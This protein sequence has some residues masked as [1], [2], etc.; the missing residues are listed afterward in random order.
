VAE[1]DRAA[2]LISSRWEVGVPI[3]EAN[4]IDLNG[5]RAISLD[6]KMYHQDPRPKRVL[7]V[8]D[9]PLTGFDRPAFSYE[10]IE[11]TLAYPN[12]SLNIV[13]G[14]GVSVVVENYPDALPAPPSNPAPFLRVHRVQ[15][16]GLIPPI[17]SDIRSTNLIHSYEVG[18]QSW[19]SYPVRLGAYAPNYLTVETG[20]STVRIRHPH[21]NTALTINVP[22]YTRNRNSRSDSA[23]RFAYEIDDV[24]GVYGTADRPLVKIVKTPGVSVT[25]EMQVFPDITA[26]LQ[27]RASPPPPVLVY[28]DI[29]EVSG[30]NR[31]PV[32]GSPITPRSGW[33]SVTSVKWT[34]SPSVTVAQAAFDTAI[35]FVP[36]VG[37][38]V[39]LAEFIYALGSGVD[40]W[41]RRQ[42]TGDLVLLGICALLPLAGV[43]L[44]RAG[45]RLLR[46]FGSRSE[47][48]L[49]TITDLQRARLSQEELADLRQAETLI[50]RGQRLP[51]ALLT[52]YRNVLD[53]MRRDFPLAQDFLNP[54]RN[55]FIN[56][57]LQRFYQAHRTRI[58]AQ[59]GTPQEPLAWVRAT[60]GRSR[61]LL[62]QLLGPDFVARLN[63]P[64]SGRMINLGDVPRPRGYSEQ[65][66]LSHINQ[67]NRD[68]ARITDRLTDFLAR[69]RTGGVIASFMAA[70]R[71]NVGYLWILKGNIAESFSMS[72]Q[73]QILAALNATNPR[74][75][76][77]QGVRIQLM[78]GNRLSRELLFSD[79]IMASIIDGNLVLRG[80]VEVKSGFR[81]GEQAAEQIFRWIE[82][83]ITDGSRVVIP[84]GARILD[85]AGQ[86]RTVTQ[87]MSF[88]YDPSSSARG[89]VVNLMRTDRHVIIPRDSG[90]IGIESGM[91]VAAG[92]QLHRLP[93]SSAELDYLA[94]RMMQSL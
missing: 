49:Q 64:G 66:L 57:E 22:E 11:G 61:A 47:S 51:D 91:H 34:P 59:G 40:R 35:G 68:S 8:E 89:R 54:E 60:R 6:Y 5:R 25:L 45:P 58:L 77:F 80:I 79:N 62:E 67:L 21:T 72:L 74:T 28:W 12:D 31:V 92:V 7:L 30:V 19:V 86:E 48:A 24:N 43:G 9:T 70:R 2:V 13:A 10:Y 53:R 33:R 38:L 81:G 23:V 3:F 14:P 41:G 15:D 78:S 46:Q 56:A 4:I 88:V 84:Q 85:A 20:T 42:S 52:S 32:Q 39:D 55:G 82:R 26:L 27:G 94:A 90:Y 73:R 18:P 29:Y 71:V 65:D 63:L 1:P 87:A 44:M 36:V 50:R 16:P 76:I 69:R 83:N 17:G 37:D 93:Q 75:R